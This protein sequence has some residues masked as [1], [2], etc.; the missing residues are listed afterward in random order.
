MDIE[1]RPRIAPKGAWNAG[2]A[3]RGDREIWIGTECYGHV[4]MVGH[5]C[6]GPS[7]TCR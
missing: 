4:K 1:L 3:I 7:S 5:G 2:T 6:H